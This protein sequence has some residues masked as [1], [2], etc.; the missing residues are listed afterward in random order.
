MLNVINS[1]GVLLVFVL[2]IVMCVVV[3]RLRKTVALHSQAVDIM[4]A[5][6]K[7]LLSAAHKETTTETEN[8]DG[9]DN[10]QEV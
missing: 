6:L 7:R 2:G 10:K 8:N 5:I 9:E 1:I 3:M 4:A